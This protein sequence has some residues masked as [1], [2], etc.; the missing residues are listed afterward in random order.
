M[1]AQGAQHAS[2]PCPLGPQP[3]LQCF[4]A[5]VQ[6]R[7]TSEQWAV[8]KNGTSHF[9]WKTITKDGWEWQNVEFSQKCILWIHKIAIDNLKSYH[10]RPYDTGGNAAHFF[11]T[12]WKFDVIFLN[13]LALKASANLW[14]RQAVAI[15][16]NFSWTQKNIQNCCEMLLCF[17]R[18]V[19]TWLLRLL[20]T[21]ARFQLLINAQV[22]PTAQVL[23]ISHLTLTCVTHVSV[24]KLLQVKSR[25]DTLE[26]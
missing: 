3:S 25:V 8:E 7:C 9:N 6:R 2:E 1:R 5:T 24:Q 14:K 19:I 21:W 12:F 10:P 17:R 11:F 16:F 22:L 13:F 18:V 26:K 4:A 23:E 15:F 20:H